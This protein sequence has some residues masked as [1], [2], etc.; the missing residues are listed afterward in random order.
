MMPAHRA[1]EV[2]GIV[3]CRLWAMETLHGTAAEE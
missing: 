3:V 2:I 1:L